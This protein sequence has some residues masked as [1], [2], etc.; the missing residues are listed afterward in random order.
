MRAELVVAPVMIA[1]D[2]G[3]LDPP[4]HS[5]DLAVGPR[6]VGPGR[7]MIDAGPG[8]G[9]REGVGP[10]DLAGLERLADFRGRRPAGPRIGEVRGVVREDGMNA[11]GHG[12]D[13]AARGKSAATRR[14]A[15]GCNSAKANL[16]VRSIATKRWSR[17][18][19]AWTSAISMW[20][21][22]TG[23]VLNAFLGR[24]PSTSG[25]RLMPWRWKHRCNEERVRCGMFARRA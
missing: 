2:R 15:V 9:E 14:V 11:V 7:P 18:S 10:E 6:V 25:S 8:A 13:R 21:Q 1:S 17:P 19:P 23:Y 24:Y 16:P 5:L 22:P 3:L 20:K 4:V 12:R